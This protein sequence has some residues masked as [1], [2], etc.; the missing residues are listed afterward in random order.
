MRALLLLLLL[1]TSPSC[2]VSLRL[3]ACAPFL[4]VCVGYA[5]DTQ[6]KKHSII[7][8]CICTQEYIFELRD[9]KELC[10]PDHMKNTDRKPD[11]SL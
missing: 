2:G 4:C 6:E 8:L 11:R 5:E 3:G 1:P 10:E 9:P 7:F